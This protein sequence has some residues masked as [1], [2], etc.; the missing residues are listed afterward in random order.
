M[1]DVLMIVTFDTGL[2]TRDILLVSNKICRALLCCFIACVNIDKQAL[3]SLI[4]Y[5]TLTL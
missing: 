2:A 5:C 1:L 3:S 4:N